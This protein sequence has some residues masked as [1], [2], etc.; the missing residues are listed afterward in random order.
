MISRTHLRQFIAV[1]DA[2]NFTRAAAQINVTQ[3]TLSAGISELEKR[4][5]A[6]LFARNNRRVQLTEA[7]NRLLAHARAIEREFRDAEESVTGVAAPLQPIRLGVLASLPTALIEAALA[8][9]DGPEPI[10]LSEGNDRELAGALA[11]GRIDIAVTLIHPGD[12]RRAVQRLFDE[13]YLLAM[14]SAHRL[15][16]RERVSAAEVAGETMIAR[17]ACEVL[18]KTSRHF[19]ER[20]VRPPFS[21]RSANDDRA[22]AMVRAGL[23]ITVAPRSLAGPG[24]AMARLDGF[25]ERREIG[26]AFSPQARGGLMAG[27]PL[28]D[29]LTAAMRR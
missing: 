5:G 8:G 27:K 21:F 22:M 10:E 13:D 9:Y 17:R 29:R 24:I 23:G 4:L 25:D 14:P 6:Q 1:V 20:G 26:L 2:G 19:T 11:H 28:A 7:G 15:A 16:G 12:D 3:P 18:G